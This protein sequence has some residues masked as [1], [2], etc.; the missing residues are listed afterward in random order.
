MMASIT[1]VRLMMVWP[2]RGERGGGD[3]CRKAYSIYPIFVFVLPARRGRVLPPGPARLARSKCKWNVPQLRACRWGI[4]GGGR[5]QRRRR[6]RA[7]RDTRDAKRPRGRAMACA[8]R[9]ACRASGAGR[10]GRAARLRG[11]RTATRTSRRKCRRPR[12]DSLFNKRGAYTAR[13]VRP[14]NVRTPF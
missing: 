6:S 8:P 5:G 12:R 14:C 13:T 4:T 10:A 9:R 3:S 11:S 1:A 7:T 2:V